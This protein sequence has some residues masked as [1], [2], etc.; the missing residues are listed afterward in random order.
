VPAALARVAMPVMVTHQCG[1]AHEAAV[2]ARYRQLGLEAQA[3]VVP[4]IDDMPAAL[5]DAELVLSRAGASATSEICAVGRPSVL[6]PYPF[7]AGDHQRRNAESLVEAGAAVCVPNAEATPT[8]LARELNA[9][10]GVRGRLLG[11]AERAQALG[12]PEAAVTIARDLLALG[13]LA[14]QEAG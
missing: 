11:L 9:I 14:L 5:A 3:R 7:A 10:F 13:G 8:R 12:R 6:V 4:F 2:G 1:R